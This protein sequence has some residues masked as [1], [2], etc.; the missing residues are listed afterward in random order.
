MKGFLHC[1]PKGLLHRILDLSGPLL[2]FEQ[3]MSLVHP[4]HLYLRDPLPD[5]IKLPGGILVRLEELDKKYRQPLTGSP[6][7][8]T[9]GRSGLAL[10]FACVYVDEALFHLISNIITPPPDGSPSYLKRGL[11]GGNKQPPT[12]REVGGLKANIQ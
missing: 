2:F 5:D 12:H 8:K 6:Y 3:R 1:L 10:T 9:Y 4:Y 7:G 11:G